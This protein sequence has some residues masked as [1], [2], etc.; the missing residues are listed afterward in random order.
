MTTSTIGTGAGL[1]NSAVRYTAQGKPIAFY[2]FDHR[3]ASAVYTSAHELVRFGMFHLED[4]LKDQRPVLKDATLDAM[5][6]IATPGDT[7]SG[8]GLGWLIGT[9]QG[10]RVVSH[11]GGM[12]G[13]ATTLKLYPQHNVVI[14]ALANTSGAAPIASRSTSPPRCFQDTR[15]QRPGA[16]PRRRSPLP[17]RRN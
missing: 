1:A 9:E 3:A 11:T 8:Y 6:R 10:M 16:R 2:D 14:L 7:A 4:H 12:P 5:H 13:V 15:R 17:V